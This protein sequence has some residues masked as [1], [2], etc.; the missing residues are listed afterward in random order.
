MQV[1]VNNEFSATFDVPS[2]IEGLTFGPDVTRK[3]ETFHTLWVANDNDFVLET[4]DTPPVANP[5][6]FFVFGFTDKDL[7]TSV[8]VPQFSERGA[9]N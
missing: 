7:G 8:F 9:G 6:Q 4:G 2:K 3:G 5:N 1:L